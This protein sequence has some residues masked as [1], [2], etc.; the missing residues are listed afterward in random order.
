MSQHQTVG[1]DTKETKPCR[2]NKKC[3]ATPNCL[4]HV[5]TPKSVSQHQNGSPYSL[6]VATPTV[7]R[8]GMKANH[9]ATPILPNQ[10]A[11]PFLLGLDRARLAPVSWAHA[12]AI[13]RV[14]APKAA[15]PCAHARPPCPHP[16]AYVATPPAVSRPGAGNR[17]RPSQFLPCTP[18]FFSIFVLSTV[19]PIKIALLLQRLLNHGK[20]NKMY[21]LYKNE[22]NYNLFLI[23]NF[24]KLGL[25]PKFLQNTK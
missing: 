7:G 25:L 16:A 4:T 11:T 6:C 1:R 9:V 20:L 23:T 12:S 2:N 18:L 24:P 21:S 14:V 8:D 13:T 5:A 15:Q 22:F 17:L 10:V 3:V 19:K